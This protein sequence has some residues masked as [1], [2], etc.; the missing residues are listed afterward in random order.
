MQSL[1]LWFHETLSEKTYAVDVPVQKLF[2]SVQALSV[3]RLADKKIV[4]AVEELSY[5]VFLRGEG[6]L[7]AAREH[8]SKPSLTALLIPSN[9]TQSLREKLAREKTNEEPVEVLVTD[10]QSLVEPIRR[11]RSEYDADLIGI[12]MHHPV[13]KMY[14]I[15][16][17]IIS[18][19]HY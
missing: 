12:N 5:R 19:H 8:D 15:L 13:Y 4:A 2:Q 17:Y 18:C 1:S 10:R 6:P 7:H 9:V 11:S 3:K 14:V 16:I